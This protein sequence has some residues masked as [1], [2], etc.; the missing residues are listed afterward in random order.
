MADTNKK[1]LDY[2]QFKKNITS[3]ERIESL[4]NIIPWKIFLESTSLLI[5]SIYCMYKSRWN[6]N[7]ILRKS[8]EL[9]LATMK[10]CECG[11]TILMLTYMQLSCTYIQ[12]QN[13]DVQSY[14]EFD[15]Y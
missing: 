14:F 11:I 10:I 8:I 7:E 3:I 15:E 4:L 9:I 1:I 5:S 6:P 2:V 13:L 12:S